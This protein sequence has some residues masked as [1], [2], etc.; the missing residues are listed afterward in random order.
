MIPQSRSLVLLLIACA[1]LRGDFAPADWKL[2]RVILGDATGLAT[3]HLD[4]AVYA[5]S[6][7]DLADL[8]V[9]RDNLHPGARRIGP[10]LLPG[11]FDQR[12]QD[13]R[14][15]LSGVPAGERLVQEHDGAVGLDG[16]GKFERIDSSAK[17]NIERTRGVF[18]EC[19]QRKILRARLMR[20][21]HAG[22]VLDPGG[23]VCADDGLQRARKHTRGRLL[24]AQ[25]HGVNRAFIERV[26]LHGRGRNLRYRD[27]MNQNQGETS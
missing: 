24:A 26:A 15:Q 19:S 9:V 22:I 13:F 1:V 4:R 5:G 7:A 18:L 25:A 23:D 8:R 14:S 12:A 21:E 3:I 27:G 16:G 20:E 11:A 17:K 2:R 10:V 6:E